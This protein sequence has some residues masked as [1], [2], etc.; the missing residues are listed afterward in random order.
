MN[1]SAKKNRSVSEALNIEVSTDITAGVHDLFTVRYSDQPVDNIIHLIANIPM[2]S[3]QS[4]QIFESWQGAV[5]STGAHNE[6][7]LFK[8]DQYL[9]ACVP[10]ALIETLPID[11]AAEK[12]YTEIFNQMHINDYPFLVRTWNFFS[13]ITDDG[14]AGSN[15]YQQFCSGRARAYQQQPLAE[16]VYPAATVIGTQQPG[17]QIYFIAAKQAG[18]GIENSLQVS[19][20]EYPAVYSQDPP[21]FSRALLHRNHSQEILFVSGTAS[22]TGHDT[23]YAGD[24]NRQTEICLSNIEQLITTAVIEKNMTPVTLRDFSQFKIYIKNP[25]DADTVRTHIQQILGPSAPVYYLQGD[26]CR[27]DLSVEIE[28]LAIIPV[29]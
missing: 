11:Q 7:K 2:P 25:N 22:I 20:F 27:S 28:A 13:N 9:L 29:N 6:W 26:M 18:I 10:Q 24:I 21:L 3:L 19:A 4:D 12:A 5:N 14:Y 1:T 17:L 16:Q 8:N 23:Q 15:N